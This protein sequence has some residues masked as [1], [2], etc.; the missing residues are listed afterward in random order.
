MASSPID[1]ILKAYR[2][3]ANNHKTFIT[4]GSVKKWG[5]SGSP[6]GVIGSTPEKWVDIA[7]MRGQNGEKIIK[8]FEKLHM[9]FTPA[10]AATTDATDCAFD[11]PI[12]YGDGSTDSLGGPSIASVWDVFVLGDVALIANREY[13]VCELTAK[14]PFALGGGKIFA[15]IENNA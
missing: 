1:G 13:P 15:S 11:I 8:Q 4:A 5:P 3:D 2:I 9:T 14:Q 6:D 7:V 12:T 10:A